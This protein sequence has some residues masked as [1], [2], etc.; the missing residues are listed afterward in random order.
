MWPYHKCIV[1]ISPPDK[2]Y[3]STCAHEF[4]CCV[5]GVLVCYNVLGNG[6][7]RSRG[8]LHLG[9]LRGCLV[10][11][12]L[13]GKVSFYIQCDAI[14]YCSH[15][16]DLRFL[17]T[18]FNKFINDVSSSEMDR[19]LFS[20]Y[21]RRVRVSVRPKSTW[22][23]SH[24]S[25]KRESWQP[26]PAVLESFAKFLKSITETSPYKSNPRFAPNI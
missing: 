21:S 10:R 26:V 22:A 7:R 12:F 16:F 23:C 4:F 9:T 19:F 1:C 18:F 15:E 17:S 11:G 14:N 5:L 20:Q 8:V 25:C 2:R 24:F 13:G 3:R 6:S